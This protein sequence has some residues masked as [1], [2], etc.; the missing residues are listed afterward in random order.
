MVNNMQENI[1]TY[2]TS[3]GRWANTLVNYVHPMHEIAVVGN[4]A[5]TLATNINQKF[6]PNKMLMATTKENNEYPLLEDKTG[7]GG[8]LIYVCRNYACKLP[9][10]NIAAFEQL[11]K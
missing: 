8:T 11:L 6:I 5:T 1:G 10:D 4:E 2:P 9:V 3:F 7:N